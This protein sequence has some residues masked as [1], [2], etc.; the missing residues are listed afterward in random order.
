MRALGDRQL[1]QDVTSPHPNLLPEGEGIGSVSGQIPVDALAGR[2]D[3]IKIA[4][5]DT[6]AHAPYSSLSTLLGFSFVGT[7]EPR[8]DKSIKVR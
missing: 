3:Q 1:V 4:V 6:R 7:G 2:P 5:A 8:Q